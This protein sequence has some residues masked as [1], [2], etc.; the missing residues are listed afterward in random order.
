MA[1]RISRVDFLI[2]GKLRCVERFAPYNYGSDDLHGHLGYLVTTWLSPGLHRFTARAVLTN[3]QKASHT[4][5]A[6]A[7]P[8]PRPP[9]ALAGRWQRTVA[10]KDIPDHA[11]RPE[12]WELVF[13]RVGAW[14]LDPVGTGIVQHV[15]FRGDTIRID[16]AV[17]MTSYVNG[18]GKLDRY[19]HTDIGAGFREDV[20]PGRYRWSI[21]GDRLTLAAVNEPWRP[22]RAV[23]HGIWTRVR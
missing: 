16:G 8:A 4:V 18:H 3:G 11:V 10:D 9:P 19:G 13:D 22:R 5:V 2:D 14:N 7:L 12:K 20:P 1:K 6:R 15:N 17:W 21:S 23:W